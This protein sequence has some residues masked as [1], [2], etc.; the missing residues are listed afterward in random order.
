MI[1]AAQGPGS[2]TAPAFRGIQGRGGEGIG[3]WA[4]AEAAASAS[5][6]AETTIANR[7]IAFLLRGVGF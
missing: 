7:R 1:R 3:C 6:T 2:G 5:I 4:K